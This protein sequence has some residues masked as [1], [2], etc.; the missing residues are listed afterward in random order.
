MKTAIVFIA[1]CAL[2]G[3]AAA[4]TYVKP[5]VK[6]DGTFVPGHVRSAPDNTPDNNYGT[7]GNYNF[8]TGQEGTQRPSYERP[9][10]APRQQ[11][12]GVNKAGVYVCR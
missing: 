10:D 7:R 9:Y 1:A 2:C 5:Y 3:L 6:S 4:Q 12:C 11:Q 8:Y